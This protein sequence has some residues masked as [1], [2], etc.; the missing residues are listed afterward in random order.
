MFISQIN[1]LEEVVLATC[2]YYGFK[3]TRNT[4]INFLKE[5]PDYPSLLAISDC[6]SYFNVQNEAY[7]IDLQNLSQLDTAFIVQI[8]GDK[9]Q[10]NF[11]SLAKNEDSNHIAFLNPETHKW[12]KRKKEAFE[13]Y[14]SGYALLI[15]TTGERIKEDNY[16]IKKKNEKRETIYKWLG[17]GTFLL[18]ASLMAINIFES[19]NQ[20]T[21]IYI[22]LFQLITIAG[23]GIGS[24]L[25]LYEVDQFDPTFNQI[26]TKGKKANCSAVLSS[27]G[28]SLF[29][30]S[31]SRIGTIFFLS[32]FF[33]ILLAYNQP[34]RAVILSYISYFS[35]A[36]ISYTIYSLFYQWRIVKRWCMLC[37][38]VQVIIILQ[39]LLIANTNW[40][41]IHSPY[42]L[43]GFPAVVLV[44][45]FLLSTFIVNITLLYF[46][47]LKEN[48]NMRI[49][50][51]RVRLNP[52]IFY[53]LLSKGKKINNTTS[54]LGISLGSPN[55]NFKIVKVCNPFCAP[56]SHGHKFIEELL[57]CDKDIQVQIIFTATGNENDESTIV[58][59][60]LL[61]IA[62]KKDEE[63]TREALNDWYSA[64]KKD[65]KIF[66]EKYKHYDGANQNLKVEAMSSWCKN[67]K[68]SF[69]PTYFING[70]QLPEG[71]SID[72]I[73]FFR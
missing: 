18:L 34:I 33:S 4:V 70:S 39:N 3:I 72:E 22:L 26:C 24:I 16:E 1:N 40:L 27:K 5:H 51:Q 61:A 20:L 48:Q 37:L 11:F 45:S 29:G 35:L 73:K 50:L 63:L 46:K 13:K 58:V 36:G 57:N 56:C 9:S 71:Y 42:F 59:K 64:P 55:A 41:T 53:T 38:S 21:A 47:K 7:N 32:Q 49:S 25:L 60:H 69:T 17:I 30:V 23:V 62:E 31:W 43:K 2:E 14:Y 28:A 67:T 15:I 44:L 65:Y 66:K 12:E 10:Q 52:E 6:F 54:S 19:E 8:Q 68:I